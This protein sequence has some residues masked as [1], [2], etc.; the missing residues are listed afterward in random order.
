MATHVITRKKNESVVIGDAIT[1]TVIGIDDEKVRLGIVCPPGTS[2]HRV[3]S[4]DDVIPDEASLA[5]DD[6]QMRFIDI[7]ASRVQEMQGITLD[8][9]VRMIDKCAV[10]A[11]FGPQLYGEGEISF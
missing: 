1:I 3:N 8:Q 10:E 2:I 5:L 4:C 9:L 11:H 7:P 6:G